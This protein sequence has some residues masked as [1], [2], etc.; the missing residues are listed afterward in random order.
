MIDYEGNNVWPTDEG[1]PS[2]YSIGVSLGR[3]PRFAGHTRDW[4]PVLA[5]TLTVAR[6]MTP[7]WAV[8]GLLHDAAESVIGDCVATWKPKELEEIEAGI[9]GRIYA[10]QGVELPTPE[11]VEMVKK[12]DAMALAAEAHVCGHPAAKEYWPTYS[13]EVAELTEFHLE[14]APSMLFAEI[15]GPI[16]VEAF[17][18]YVPKVPEAAK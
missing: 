10:K 13:D 2:L 9:L 18:H 11:A 15:A 3:I 16:F 17:N 7:E 6:L 5:H 4:Y 12:A 1:S 8:H 14:N